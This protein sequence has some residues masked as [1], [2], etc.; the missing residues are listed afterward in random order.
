M[1]R[2]TVKG[3]PPLSLTGIHRFAAETADDLLIL[4]MKGQIKMSRLSEL[5]YLGLPPMKRK[6]YDI[7]QFF[8]NLPLKILN[9]LKQIP[10][11]IWKGICA[12]GRFFASIGKI[13]GP[14]DSRR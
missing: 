1:R 13:F 6:L 14:T 7:G 5:E 9:I 2:I 4:M 11:G 10:L 3:L 12:V 8:V